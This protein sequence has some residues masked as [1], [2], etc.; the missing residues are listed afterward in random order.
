LIFDNDGL[1]FSFFPASLI[2]LGRV[3]PVNYPLYGQW[4]YGEI[5]EQVF[6]LSWFPHCASLLQMANFIV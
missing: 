4:H 3:G 1:S 2:A 5:E 6:L